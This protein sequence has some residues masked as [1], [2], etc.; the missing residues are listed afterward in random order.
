[1]I[2]DLFGEGTIDRCRLMVVAFS[3]AM[4]ERSAERLE[5]CG[6]SDK[7]DKRRGHD[8][9]R[10]WCMKK[11]VTKLRAARPIMTRF[12]SARRPTLKTASTTI[13]STAALSPKNNA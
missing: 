9:Q 8:D 11:I 7:A 3:L 1:M 2:R 6:I 13:A 4:T 5:A 12:F 10:E